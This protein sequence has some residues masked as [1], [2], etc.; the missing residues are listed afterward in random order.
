MGVFRKIFHLLKNYYFI[1][2]K[3]GVEYARSLG[4]TIGSDCRVLTSSFG[5]EPW[6]ITIGNKVTITS[7]VRLLTHDGATWLCEDKKGRRYSYKKITIGDNVF[8]GTNSILMPGVKIDHNVIVA[9]GSVVTKSV[10]TGVI[11]GGNPAKIIGSYEDYILR[12][13]EEYVTKADMD[14]N[15][16][17]K[18]RINEVVDPK[19]KD[20][21]N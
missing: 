18:Q 19:F 4:V 21:L 9:A 3:S 10:P 1:F 13:K 16:S 15:K 17:K 14:Y 6:L 5:S 7:G 12:A 8:I 11:V 2:T 20:Y